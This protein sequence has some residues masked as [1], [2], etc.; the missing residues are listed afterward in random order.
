MHPWAKG[1][2][3][4]KRSVLALF[5][6]TVFLLTVA[7]LLGRYGREL[8]A[9]AVE[10]GAGAGVAGNGDVNGD[11]RIDIS[12][13]SYL[14]NFLFL[15]GPRP[16]ACTGGRS[17]LPDTGQTTCFDCSGQPVACRN[18]LGQ[19]RPC[20]GFTV[21]SLALQD[22]LQNTGCPNDAQRFTIRLDDTV[23]D[24]CTGL[25][26]Q[27]FTADRDDDGNPD[28][29]D[30]CAALDYCQ[31]LSFAGHSDWRL[32]N[33][34]ELQSIVDYGRINPA[35]DPLF[36]AEST[37][38]WS[39]TSATP[40]PSRAWCISFTFGTLETVQKGLSQHQVPSCFPPLPPAKPV[41]VRA[42]RGGR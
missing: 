4:M 34:R 19:P 39:S 30:W 1:I 31:N 17:G 10:G 24:N 15:G 37:V 16:V 8:P 14:L 20:D 21:D 23:I 22:A 41:L 7:L 42:V 3:V 36:R 5:L 28:E 38:Y 6:L 27:R 25:Q 32:P 35:A 26:W 40:S 13:A 2:S 29:F 12:D 9:H 18:C 11:G 33:V